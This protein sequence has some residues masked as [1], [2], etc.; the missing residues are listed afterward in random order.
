MPVIDAHAH[1]EPRAFAIDAMLAE[2]DRN[3]VDQVALIA[4][5]CDVL[6]HTPTAMLALARSLMRSPWPGLARLLN[7]MFMTADGDLKLSGHTYRIYA[8]PDNQA[9]ADAIAAHPT[10]FRGWIFV[11][12]RGLNHTLD[13]IERWRQRPGFIGV[14]IHP[15]WHGSTMA[16]CLPL[17]RRCEELGLPLLIHLG[18]GDSGDWSLLVQRCPR[19]AMVL[20]HAGIPHFQRLWRDVSWN[21]NLHID[22]SS[23]FLNRRL[24][25]DAV[26]AVGPG[27]ALY[28]TDSPYGFQ[29]PDGAYDYAEIKGWIEEL[30]LPARDIDRILGGNAAAL[31]R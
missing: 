28:G 27:R 23:P 7:D 22:L 17:A 9:V 10:R 20:A 13:E 8:D 2:M 21:T 25:A 26:A 4:T 1:L 12:P 24:V 30:P 3:G 18:F 6:P 19:L 31:F 5:L 15:H 16:E 29:R 14:K 11:N